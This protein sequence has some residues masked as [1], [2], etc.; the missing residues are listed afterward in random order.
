MIM[1]ITTTMMMI[2]TTTTTTIIILITR[3]IEKGS[4]K[5]ITGISGKINL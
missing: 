1:T 5:F 4:G 2:I 3:I